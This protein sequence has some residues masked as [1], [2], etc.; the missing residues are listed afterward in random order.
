MLLLQDEAGWGAAEPL[1]CS[2][3]PEKAP[4]ELGK[5]VNCIT[6]GIYNLRKL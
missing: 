1:S 6:T 2:L 3:V 5:H 4:V